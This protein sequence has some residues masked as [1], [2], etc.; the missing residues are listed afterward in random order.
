MNN[1]IDPGCPFCRA[2]VQANSFA[3]T[4]NFL[5]IYNISPV[6]PGHSMVIPRRHLPGLMDLSDPQLCEMSLFARDVIKVL[7]KAFDQRDFDWTI[8]DGAAAGQTV[9]HLHLHLIPRKA[10]DLPQPGDWYP[11]LEQNEHAL[12]DSAS[13]PRYDEQAIAAITA[14]LKQIAAEV[15]SA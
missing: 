2:D 12:L 13:R 4:E 1:E 10:G 3:E 8:Q 6:L 11:L 7:A 5:A 9:A 15:L 14:Q